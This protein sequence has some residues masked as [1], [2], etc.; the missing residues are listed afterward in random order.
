MK[1]TINKVLNEISILRLLVF[2]FVLFSVLII[3]SI[4]FNINIEDNAFDLASYGLILFYFVYK[5]RNI[6]N[7]FK[8][9]L[10]SSC[11]LSNI[12]EILFVAITNIFLAFGVL[13][14][15]L[16]IGIDVPLDSTTN[17][18]NFFNMSGE[19][20]VIVV[21]APIVEELIFRGVFLRW[22]D[23][24]FNIY[25]AIIITSVLF[26]VMHN[27]GG[28]IS[29]IIFGVSMSILY[30]KTNNLFVPILAHMCNNFVCEFLIHFDYGN[31]LL[32]NDIILILLCICI[33]LSIILLFNYLIKNIKNI[34][35]YL[36]TFQE[37]GLE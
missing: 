13:I 7:N 24:K 4:I 30:V 17:F 33:I 28:I 27:F 14:F 12:K 34:K 32:S 2:I 19:I 36:N 11:T 18:I 35:Y 20:I 16:L 31:F 15:A 29:A 37:N 5:F 9:E 26:G 21:L 6:G 25:V 1:S 8:S 3:L 22:L 23:S 10:I